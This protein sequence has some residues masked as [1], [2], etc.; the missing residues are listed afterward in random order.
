MFAS[1]EVK[2]ILS[3]ILLTPSQPSS[4]THW[5]RW[6]NG[7]VT[8]GPSISF[9]GRHCSPGSSSR[10]R[11][12]AAVA[13]TM[14]AFSCTLLP[15]GNARRK[16]EEGPREKEEKQNP[17]KLPILSVLHLK[18]EAQPAPI[19]EIFRKCLCLAWF[20]HWWAVTKEG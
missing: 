20:L 2:P 1:P 13:L 9:H 11:G 7:S 14:R 5:P 15:W 12:D 10:H 3:N 19:S 6:E 4:C 16:P 8:G 17:A 18:K